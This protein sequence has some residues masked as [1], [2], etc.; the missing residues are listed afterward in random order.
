MIKDEIIIN[1]ITEIIVVVFINSN[2]CNHSARW[3]QFYL[4]VQKFHDSCIARPKV[5]FQI[6]PKRLTLH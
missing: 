2:L 4:D 3:L 6:R 5:D 1:S